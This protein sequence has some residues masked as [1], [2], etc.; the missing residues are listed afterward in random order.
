[1]AAENLAIAVPREVNHISSMSIRESTA[2]SVPLSPLLFD[3]DDG[4]HSKAF[5]LVAASKV[6]VHE[7]HHA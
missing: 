2:V 3:I 1:M 5:F 6:F 7:Y 4:V